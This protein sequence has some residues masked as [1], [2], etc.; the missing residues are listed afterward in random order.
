M[1]S[2]V[3]IEKLRMQ[4]SI[5]NTQVLQGGAKKSS[6]PC[7]AFRT[8]CVDEYYITPSRFQFMAGRCF[9]IYARYSG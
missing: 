9:P 6:A 1:K 2:I 3:D 4:P 7:F 8:L 5:K